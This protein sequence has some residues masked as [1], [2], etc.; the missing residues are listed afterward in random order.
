MA[1]DRDDDN[2]QDPKSAKLSGL[3]KKAVKI[4]A[5][6]YIVAEDTVS[7]TLNSAQLPKEFLKEAL[8]SLF[9]S[10][11]LQVTAEIKLKPK[12]KKEKI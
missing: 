7:K 9:E 2:E 6:T 4:G 10:Y 12:E 8:E 3:L 1:D 11:T 5:A